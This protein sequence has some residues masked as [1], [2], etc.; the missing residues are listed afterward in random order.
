MSIDFDTYDLT[1]RQKGVLTYLVRY[2]K[3]NGISP[4]VREIM[5]DLGLKSPSDI[6][7]ILNVLKEKGYILSDE[8]KKRSWRF[9]GDVTGDG[10]PVIGAI[11]AGRPTEALE[12]AEQELS[13]SPKVFGVNAC[14]ALRVKGDSMIDAHI[15]DGD[16]A[17]I[18]PQRR[19]EHG[20]IAAVMVMNQ[21]PEATLKIVQYD[22]EIIRLVAANDHMPTMVFE[23]E[24]C[25]RLTIIGKCVGVVRRFS[26]FNGPYG[27]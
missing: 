5:S 24:A 19:V 6:H 13:I 1:P 25:N 26:G 12:N 22:A 11:A 3:T 21:M 23:G 17:V 9:A 7:R 4:T 18:R 2:Q 27:K 14:F 10:I 8:G 16:L 20:E 15:M